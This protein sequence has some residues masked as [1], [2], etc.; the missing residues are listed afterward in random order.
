MKIGSVGVKSLD[1]FVHALL[2]SGIL[3]FL[4]ALTGPQKRDT[5]GGLSFTAL[6]LGGSIYS[7]GYYFELQSLNIYHVFNWLRFEYISVPFI[8]VLWML[9]ILQYTDRAKQL[10]KFAPAALFIIPTITFVL[11][12]T[13]D[14]H[15]LFYRCLTLPTTNPLSIVLLEK[16]PW[17]WVHISYS[18]ISFLVGSFILL[19][20][21]L[22]SGAYYR[23]R[24][25]LLW[26]GSLVPWVC[27][28][29]YLLG[30]S[31]M[32]LDLG[33]FG[34]IFAGIITIYNLHRHKLFD[35]LPVAR[36][37]LFETIQDCVLVLDSQNRLADMNNAASVLFGVDKSFFGRPA[38]NL[39]NIFQI[40]DPLQHD[41]KNIR[42]F[43][44]QSADS[45]NSIACSYNSGD[46]IRWVD[47]RVSR[48]YDQHEASQGCIIIIRDITESKQAENLLKI[49]RD[50]ALSLGNAVKFKETLDLCLDA[51]I[52]VS[53][54]D[55][56]AMYLLDETEKVFRLVCHT[57]F[58]A[59]FVEA[60]AHQEPERAG[61]RLDL[62]ERP[63]Y[64]R[65]RDLGILPDE[66]GA[67]CPENLEAVAVI[68]IRHDDSTIACMIIASHTHK[69]APAF[70]RT[71]LETIAGQ[72]G[73]AIAR[74]LYEEKLRYFSMHDALTGLYNRAYFQEEL[75]RLSKSRE[76]PITILS[77]DV[78]GLKPINDNLGHIMGDTL[79]K[80]CGEVLRKS[81][82][83]S[84]LA[85]RLGGDEFAIVLPRSDTSI[86]QKI[87]DRIQIL[88]ENYNRKHS[89]LPLRISI[90]IA[91]AK[92]DKK[93]LKEIYK[94]ADDLMYKNKE[95]RKKRTL[96][97][98]N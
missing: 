30:G 5:R 82:R 44:L 14:I 67:E 72:V 12:L 65:Y 8:P 10:K 19:Y 58:S 52:K 87:A 1:F 3:Y 33:P 78:D 71:A 66:A 4:M 23:K 98:N 80:A 75:L 89:E 9:F 18:N 53:L 93:P 29:I 26:I 16:G 57:G 6:M 42:D 55:S 50:L 88:I 68:P 15:H 13:N 28:I 70:S 49:Q 36:A 91:T 11:I 40:Q 48:L 61:I 47:I 81:I 46:G 62:V 96:H 63:V 73:Q 31:P 60:T 90:G 38:D 74:L 17:Y 45:R 97:A 84:D 56:G 25:F 64:T 86:G 21:S 27:M 35:L 77:I 94:Q 20:S 92:S 7:I 43:L 51:A 95:I 24:F 79:L 59:S 39:F 2:A 37:N 54:M 22:Q 32:N 69:E 34:L 85:A 76:Y 83:S 41:S